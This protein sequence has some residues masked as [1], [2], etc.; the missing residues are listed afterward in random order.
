MNATISLGTDT[1]RA[2]AAEVATLLE[3]KQASEPEPW[4]DVRAA[5]EHLACKP[6][7]VYDL[8]SQGRIPH[9]KDGTRLLFRRSELDLSLSQGALAS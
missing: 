3:G 1:L 4:V 6:R 2:L 8:V 9:V 7:R 5:A